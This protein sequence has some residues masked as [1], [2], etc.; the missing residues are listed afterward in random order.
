VQQHDRLTLAAIDVVDLDAAE[1]GVAAVLDRKRG[2][3]GDGNQ[4]RSG[5]LDGSFH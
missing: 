5:M 2:R 1:I 3:D 4:N